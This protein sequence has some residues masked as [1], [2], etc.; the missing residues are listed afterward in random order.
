MQLAVTIIRPWAMEFVITANTTP[1]VFTVNSA[2]ISFTE[3]RV[4]HL[5][6]LQFVCVSTPFEQI[7]NNYYSSSPNG[8]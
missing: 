3:T 4:N 6:M 2:S 5:M 1:P 7:I 8:L